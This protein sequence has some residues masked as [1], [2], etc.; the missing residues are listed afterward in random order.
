MYDGF[1][2]LPQKFLSELLPV[3]AVENAVKNKISSL[4]CNKVGRSVV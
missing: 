2:F 4:S 1:F 3:F